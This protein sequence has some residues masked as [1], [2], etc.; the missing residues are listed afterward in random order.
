[1]DTINVINVGGVD[2]EIEDTYARSLGTDADSRLDTLEPKVTQEISDR[3]N[4]DAALN[5]R[6]DQIVAPTG[7]AP[8]PA[9]ITDA[10]IG[11]DG[12]TYN[13][14]GTS[15]R[16]QIKNARNAINNEDDYFSSILESDL[17]VQESVIDCND[18][19]LQNDGNLWTILNKTKT[20]ITAQRLQSGSSDCPRLS[21]TLNSGVYYLYADF[22]ESNIKYFTKIVNGSYS[23][24]ANGGTITISADNTPVALELGPTTVNT[25]TIKS[26]RLIKGDR[27]VLKN[28][29][30]DGNR[31]FVLA[32][33]KY[34]NVD[35][36]N[37]KVTIPSGYIN[38]NN[39][40][41]IPTEATEISLTDAYSFIYY[42]F[43]SGSMVRKTFQESQNLLNV[44]FIAMIPSDANGIPMAN[45]PIAVNG[46]LVNRQTIDF[47]ASFG[48]KYTTFAISPKQE[49]IIIDQRHRL[50][51][52][53]RFLYINHNGN[54]YNVAANDSF[55]LDYKG[56]GSYTLKC[57]YFDTSKLSTIESTGLTNDCF[58]IREQK[59][60]S[61]P[62][63]KYVLIAII[64]DSCYQYGIRPIAI[65]DYITTGDEERY[66]LRIEGTIPTPPNVQALY[67]DNVPIVADD[68][69]QFAPLIDL[70]DELVE[71]ANRVNG[72]Y[73]KKCWIDGSDYDDSEKIMSDLPT[74]GDHN[75]R[76]DMNQYPLLMYKLIPIED[77]APYAYNPVKHKILISAGIHG[78]SSGG[79]HI[80]S[81]VA[82]YYMAKRIVEE[83]YLTDSLF[84]IRRNFELDIIP[85]ANPWG[86]N[87]HQRV[88]G[89]NIDI[90]RD[91]GNFQTVTAQQMKIL[92]ESGEYDFYWD[93]H[94][95]GGIS[96]TSGDLAGA[97]FYWLSNDALSSK[98]GDA[99]MDFIGGKYS[100]DTDLHRMADGTAG[101]Y[102]FLSGIMST[103][104]ELPAN[105][106]LYYGDTVGDPHGEEVV[107]RD[108]DFTQNVI[109]VICEIL[110]K[111]NQVP[112]VS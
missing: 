52:F 39:G 99:L 71:R 14:L 22:S 81:P 56:S 60:V 7:E 20:S 29:I 80:E 36:T 78:G 50:I 55:E 98:I 62:N 109:A 38:V 23:A 6:I 10:R 79:D 100:L 110:S 90:N 61:I 5:T 106:P 3:A 12:K 17:M 8:N 18:F 44:I 94:C 35:Y 15:I 77:N 24:I 33:K 25:Y 85:V 107:K 102:A 37:M 103:T 108:S 73:M 74:T 34:I 112:F 72:I 70:W 42:D 16:T 58:Y 95:L 82:I 92:M 97:N 89:Q 69:D 57:I 64:P 83:F 76:N 91:F 101:K 66:S 31:I 104:T 86:I 30:I 28:K 4:A 48:K 2:K 11:A 41:R 32:Q 49:P 88:N 26:I 63:E 59:T 96:L 51:I 67:G 47:L 68:Y 40:A 1:M 13:S 84:N 54:N 65:F 111:Y 19:T 46:V 105:T 93:S 9:E 27:G 43:T 53:P 75:P 87:N 21:F 45:V